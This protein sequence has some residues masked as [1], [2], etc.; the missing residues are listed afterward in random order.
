LIFT[1]TRAAILGLATALFYKFGWQYKKLFAGV[2]LI[3]C[4]AIGGMTLTRP[5]DWSQPSI[6]QV[7]SS[8]SPLWALS[9]QGIKKRAFFGWGFDGFGIAYSYIRNPKKTPIV[10]NL[11]QF[12]YFHGIEAAAIAYVVFAITWFD[13]DQ[14]AHIPSWA[15][16]IGGNS[17]NHREKRRQST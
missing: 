5:L 2:T 10:V 6:Q 9:L 12:T 15:L 1:T 11:D 16:S 3:I 7:M 14:Y 8:P 4:L 17:L 13:S